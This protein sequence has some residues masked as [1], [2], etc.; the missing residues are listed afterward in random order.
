MICPRCKSN[1][2][3]NSVRCEVC[4]KKIKKTKTSKN[5][6]LKEKAK[7]IPK[8]TKIKLLISVIVTVAIIV[9]IL[10]VIKKVGDNTGK[11]LSESLSEYIGEPVKVAINETDEYFADDSNYSALNSITP[12]NY[13]IEAKKSVSVDGVNYPKWAIF[14]FTNDSDVIEQIKYVDFNAL[15]GNTKGYETKREINLD[16]FAIGDKFRVVNKEIDIEPFMITYRSGTI[17]YDY[18]YY[19][20]ND[21]KDEQGMT[22]SVALDEDNGYVYSTSQPIIPDWIY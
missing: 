20:K 2:P 8:E 5:S 9:L 17:I 12:F 18:R 7:A 1:I 21:S 13:I 6:A 14:I 11:N 22:L 3:D 19:F 16:K 4:D 10:L 15:K